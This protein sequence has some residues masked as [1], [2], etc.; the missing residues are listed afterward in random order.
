MISTANYLRLV[1]ASACY[2]LVATAGFATPW[3]FTAMLA[4]LNALANGLGVA[5]RLPPFA[6]E[7]LLMANL[8]GSIVIVWAILRLRAP[9]VQ[10]GR[11]DAVGRGLFATWQ[12]YALLHGA[13][14]FIWGFFA[15]EVTFGILQALPPGR[16]TVLPVVRRKGL[17]RA[18]HAGKLSDAGCPAGRRT[19]ASSPPSG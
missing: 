14:P 10:Y 4:G 13:H 3:T 17:G 8:L 15:V 18:L 5:Q 12:F 9:S 6:P 16:S 1:R 7:H 11:Y 2:D 19:A